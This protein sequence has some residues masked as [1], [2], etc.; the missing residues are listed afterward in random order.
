MKDLLSERMNEN[1]LS[2]SQGFE[3]G[4]DAL[5]VCWRAEAL[6]DEAY[7]A[8]IREAHLSPKPGLVDALTNGAH[9]DMTLATFVASAQAL[10]PLLADFVHIGSASAEEPPAEVFAS[11]RQHGLVC[12]A[13]MLQATAGV[14][15]HKGAIFAFGLLLGAA[16]RLIGSERTLVVDV[17]CDEAADLVQGL[18]ETDLVRGHKTALTAGEYIFQRYGLRGARGEACS[19]FAT[20]RNVALPALRA[21]WLAGLQTEQALL[22][23]LLALLAENDDTNLV[24]RGGMEGLA[25]VKQRARKLMQMGGIHHGGIIEALRAFDD[26][27]IARNLSPGGSAD[28]LAVTWFLSRLE[29]TDR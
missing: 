18:V 20:V 25:Y 3:A 24:A 28:L 9:K 14:N 17:L 2:R 6:A 26:A 22:S 29:A 4:S 19:G 27:L 12:E 13:A 16:G 10:K 7:Q 5:P 8:L 23:S 21:A 15:T 11:L 1:A